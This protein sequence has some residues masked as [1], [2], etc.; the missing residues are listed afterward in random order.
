[1]L[2]TVWPG[3]MLLVDRVLSEQISEG[4][5]VLFGRDRRLFAHRV[6]AKNAVDGGQTIT[7][8]DGMPQPDLPVSDSELLG[9]VSFIIRNGR[10]IEPS[11]TLSASER[12]V[13][14]LVRRSESVARVV[15]GVHSLRNSSEDRVSP[16]QS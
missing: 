9:R 3:D 6:V 12:A 10:C 15:V 4:D 1:M 11:K 16:C 13:A 2:P 8:G 7:Q 5:I 14:A